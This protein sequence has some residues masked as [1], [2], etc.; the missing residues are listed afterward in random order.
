MADLNQLLTDWASRQE[1]SPARLASLQ[2]QIGKSLASEAAEMTSS[3][4]FAPAGRAGSDGRWTKSA[5]RVALLVVAASLLA[6]MTVFW[7]HSSDE[8][9]RSTDVA[10]V[11]MPSV[12]LSSRQ[13]L[14][15]E[16]D[17]VFDG[18]WRWL[19]EVN[20]RVHLQTDESPV[21]ENAS[22][23]ENAGVAV[24][25]T[26]VQR[27]P[28][29]A[30]WR[31]VWEAS[32][33]AR[34]E[35]WVRLPQE[36]TGDGAV[37]VWA[38]ALPDGSVLVESDVSLAAPV[39]IRHADQHLFGGAHRPARLWSVRRADGEFQLIQSIARLETQHG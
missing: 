25:L 15:Q 35:E 38:Y 31:V 6:V 12:D 32:V 33:L 34:S 3:P 9:P 13:A 36:L 19:G 11:A 8:S 30:A 2:A 10:D 28:G 37:A 27:R 16:L 14:F 23:D 17:Q 22:A 4:Q 20:G 24:R 7:P 21:T 26:I 1:A 29:D 18:H 5:S 39:S